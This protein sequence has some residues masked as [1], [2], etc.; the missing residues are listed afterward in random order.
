MLR[1]ARC[2]AA[3][4]PRVLLAPAEGPVLVTLES[5]EDVT[6]PRVTPGPELAVEQKAFDVS[7]EH[8]QTES[9]EKDACDESHHHVHGGPNLSGR[10]HFTLIIEDVSHGRK[11]HREAFTERLP[12]RTSGRRRRVATPRH[13]LLHINHLENA[14][15]RPLTRPLGS[16]RVS[17]TQKRP[18]FPRGQI[19]RV[20]PL[21][22]KPCPRSPEY[23]P[24]PCS[25]E[26]RGVNS[27]I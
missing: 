18:R 3:P 8:D 27:E 23:R 16:I 24:V 9:C 11:E 20:Y 1:I 25:L 17:R 15:R 26:T 13:A 22:I 5:L 14:I 19:P 4:L 21:G 7:H 2:R 12:E 6:E 10:D